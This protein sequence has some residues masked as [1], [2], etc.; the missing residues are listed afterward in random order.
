MH[1]GIGKPLI[2]TTDN[3]CPFFNRVPF[4]WHRIL[5]YPPTSEII[6]S[7]MSRVWL[8]FQSALLIFVAVKLDEIIYCLLYAVFVRFWG[9]E[10]RSFCDFV[11][12]NCWSSGCLRWVS[13]AHEMPQSPWIRAFAGSSGEGKKWKVYMTRGCA[14][15][16]FCSHSS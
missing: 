13:A 7:L 12:N 4:V 10:N 3:R 2:R 11:R 14:T 5:T 9:T 16:V 1:W 6:W 8:W 15:F